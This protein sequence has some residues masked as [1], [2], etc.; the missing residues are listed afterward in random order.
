MQL[1]AGLK[2]FI[3]A[4]LTDNTDKLLLAASR[5]PGIDIR[6][7]IDQIIARRQ[8]QHKLPFWYEQDE[9]IYPSRLS[10]EQCSSEQTALYKQQLLRGNT[11]CD[12]TGGLG[13]DTFYFAQKAGNVIYVERF[14]E[15]CTAAQH[16]FKVL[17]TS[18]IHIIHSDACDIIQTLQADTFYLDPARRGNGNKRLFALTD[19]EP[20]ILQLKPLLLERARRVIVKIS[21]MADPEETLR[22]LPETREIHILAVRNECKELLF[23]L[24]GTTPSVQPVKIYAVNLGGTTA[25]PPFIFTPDEEKEAPVA[26]V[27]N[28]AKLSLRTPCCPLKK[29]SIQINRYPF[30]FIQITPAQSFIHLRIFMSGFSRPYLHYRRDL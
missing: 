29:R 11:V 26:S 6:F 14:P 22:L 12:L 30:E 27:S 15:Y 16:N 7:A 23:I 1:T 19:C 3:R 4:H 5:F 25:E 2:Q 10:T 24:E 28:L 20:D 17:N 13:I 9:L 8:I 21:P 18:N